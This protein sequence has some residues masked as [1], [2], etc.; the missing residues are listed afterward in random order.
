MA[1]K[2]NKVGQERRFTPQEMSVIRSTFR[3]QEGLLILIRRF[4]LQDELTEDDMTYLKTIMTPEV[5]SVVKKTINPT[6]DKRAVLNGTVDLLSGMDIGNVLID[7]AVLQI[8]ARKKAQEYL[9][10]RFDVLEGK[11]VKNEIKF[12][13]LLDETEKEEMYI[14]LVVRNFLL[15]FIDTQGL[16]QLQVLSYAEESPEEVKERLLKNSNK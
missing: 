4:L 8:K 1:E 9:T 15:G 12:D 3:D 7:H 11:K 5:I 16:R 6:L 13:E 10:Q 14:N 2:E